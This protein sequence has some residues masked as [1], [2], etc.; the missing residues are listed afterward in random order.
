[1][2]KKLEFQA[3]RIDEVMSLHK[4]PARVT[5]GTVTP[6][7][8]R[9]QVLPAVGTKISRIKNLSEE[10][11]AALDAPSSR[12]SR[13]GA[14]VFIEI[15]RDDPQPVRLLPLLSQLFNQ[16][17]SQPPIP[18][19]T[20]ILGLA[21]DGSPLLIR[22]P[23]PDVGHILI[24][25]NKGAGKTTLLQTI[26]LSLALTDRLDNLAFVFLGDGLRLTMEMVLRLGFSAYRIEGLG[27]AVLRA[28]IAAAG[29][30]IIV[31]A[32]NVTGDS[33]TS[34][35]RLAYMMRSQPKRQRHYIL[36]WLGVPPPEVVNLFQVRLVGRMDNVENANKA[37]GWM[38][39]G[40]ERLLGGGDF[41]AVAE[42]TANRFQAADVTFAGFQKINN[43]TIRSLHLPSPINRLA[44]GQGK[45]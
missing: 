17:T 23:S 32:D 2:R 29:K 26:I 39:T 38:G 40:A 6:R 36:A 18:P 30:R 27:M 35:G 20:A 11:A 3:D 45:V 16:P 19:V 24:A 42:G 13:H 7:W 10:L 4:V 1:M 41:L 31:V 33:H 43:K 14:S 28:G 5:G 44:L 21:E 22:L 37:T 12:V 9:F 25:G 8:V 34:I 15:P